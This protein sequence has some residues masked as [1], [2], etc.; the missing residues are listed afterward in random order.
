[1]RSMRTARTRLRAARRRRR[2]RHEPRPLRLRPRRAATWLDRRRHGRRLRPRRSAGRRRRPAGHP[3]PRGASKTNLVGIV[4]THAHEDHF[5]AL[6]RSLAAASQ[7]PVYMTPFAAGLL[8]AKRVGGADAPK[9]PVRVVQP[10][11]PHHARPVRD[12]VHPG[13][14]LHPRAERARHPHAARHGPPH[15]RLEARPDAGPRPPDRQRPA[16]GD[17][18]RGRAGAGLRF[19]QRRARGRQPERGRG[20]DGAGAADRRG[21]AARRGHHLRLA[22][23]RRLRA[24]AHRRAARRARRRHR[25][26]RHPPRDRC[27]DANSAI[28]TACRP[29]LDQ[30]AYGTCRATRS[31]R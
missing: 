7:A 19:H 9:I 4:I 21:A 30:D 31:W 14:A 13:L 17:R 29:F 25:R 2:D 11:R 12:R 15:R 23:S 26:P 18:R 3:L 27:R 1:M 6:L 8:E 5:G 16:C 20:G 24:V 10:G 28:S 22:T